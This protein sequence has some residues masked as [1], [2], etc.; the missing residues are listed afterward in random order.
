MSERESQDIKLH[1][2]KQIRENDKQEFDISLFP[3]LIK[4]KGFVWVRACV[5]WQI[6]R[7]RYEAR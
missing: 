2:N 6:R 4:K 7:V 3:M 1:K 5:T